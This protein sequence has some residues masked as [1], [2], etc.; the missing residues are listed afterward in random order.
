MAPASVVTPKA[1]LPLVVPD[2]SD[3]DG[4]AGALVARAA[5][6][7]LLSDV[8]ADGTGVTRAVLVVSPSHVPGVLSLVAEW[9]RRRRG[10]DASAADIVEAVAHHPLPPAVAAGTRPLEMLGGTV[11]LV[12]QRHP[13]GLGDA[14]LCARDALQ[15][16]GHAGPPPARFMVV[17][18][19]HLFS[20][21]DDNGGA[22][23]NSCGT[24]PQ[25]RVGSGAAVFRLL[26]QSAAAVPV[27]VALSAVGTC[28]REEVPATGLLAPPAATGAVYFDGSVAGGGAVFPVASMWEKPPP[29]TA[30]AALAAFEAPA[31]HHGAT[32]SRRYLS[33]FGVDVLPQ[34]VFQH[35]ADA[36]VAEEQASDTA[37]LT[38]DGGGGTGT[39]GNNTRSNR[40]RRE[41]C[42]RAAM[43]RLAAS[44]SLSGL[45]L[46]P[47][48]ARHDL[49]NPAAYLDT[50]RAF[51]P[52][53]PPGAAA[54]A[55][56][57]ATLDR[58]PHVGGL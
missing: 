9:A 54:C 10:K 43:A 56:P 30:L 31:S 36:A 57:A 49:G 25:Q 47:A 28:S 17:L 14:V 19:D 37:A 2:V 24:W 23:R 39:G 20:V 4:S 41:L 42:L 29:G 11:A 26:Q 32:D 51:A 46:P 33:Q 13:H 35:L 16:P 44:G 55:A 40:P 34:A 21:A 8:L 7:V 22:G 18:G 1:F 48:C 52:T 53:L 27:T 58:R 45:L 38:V 15:A 5:L 6:D 50:V 12:V 3:G